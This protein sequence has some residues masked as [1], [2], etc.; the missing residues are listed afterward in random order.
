MVKRLATTLSAAACGI[1]FAQSAC[2][3]SV[4]FM[5]AVI[6]QHGTQQLDYLTTFVEAKPTTTT[7]P[8][9]SLA[10]SFLAGQA[11]DRPPMDMA[12]LSSNPR[13]SG[14]IWFHYAQALYD[15]GEHDRAQQALKQV[16]SEARAAFEPAW[17]D[18]TLRLALRSE[19]VKGPSPDN[20]QIEGIAALNAVLKRLSVSQRQQSIERLRRLA[21]AP[22]TPVALRHRATIWATLLLAEQGETRDGFRLFNEI[23]GAS[24]LAPETLLAYT[25][26]K[27]NL[28]PQ[29]IGAIAEHIKQAAPES[30]AYRELQQLLI[31]RLYAQGAVNQAAKIALVNI[32]ELQQI[33]AR[34]RSHRQRVASLPIEELSPYIAIIPTTSQARVQRLVEARDR[35]QRS[36]HLLQE[37]Q[38]HVRSYQQI[39]QRNPTGFARQIDNA[40]SELNIKIRNSNKDT[41]TLEDLFDFELNKLLGKPPSQYAGY[42]IFTGLAQWEFGATYPRGWQPQK[43]SSAEIRRALEH[44]SQL[45]DRINNRI[46]E[47]PSFPY[48]GMSQWAKTIVTRNQSHATVIQRAM[49][50]VEQAIRDEVIASLA[51]RQQREENWLVQFSRHA[52]QLHQHYQ[53]GSSSPV[54]PLDKTLSLAAGKPILESLLQFRNERTDS[55]VVNVDFAPAMAGLAMIIEHSRSRLHLANALLLRAHLNVSLYETGALTDTRAATSHY[56]ELLSEY[57]DL[58]DTAEIT[59]HLAKAEA[60]NQEMEASLNTLMRFTQR[61]PNDSRYHEA[62]FRIGEL[63]F[64][65]SDYQF[66]RNAY[67]T[68]V[69]AGENRFSE[70]ARYKLAWTLFK[71]G[72][73]QEALPRFVAV[74]DS[75]EQQGSDNKQLANRAQDAFRA[76]SLTFS[77]LKGPISIENYFAK[78][79]TR[80]YLADVYHNLA[81]FYLDHSR[82]SDAAKTYDYLIIHFPTDH[83]A[84]TLLAGV[85]DAARQERLSKLALTL[86]EQFVD[87]Y[88]IDGTYWQTAATQTK[89]AIRDQLK[90]YLAQLAQMYH[91]DAQQQ[92]KRDS[93]S[94]AIDYYERYVAAFPHDTETPHLHFLMAEARFEKGAYFDAMVDYEKVAY[95]YGA[96][97]DAA[98]AGYAALLANQKLVV[99]SVFEDDKKTRL[100]S[101]VAR[102]RRFA[103]SF[104][105]DTRVNDVMVK[106]SED[107][108]ML[109][110]PGEAVDLGELL[111]K[112][113]PEASIQRR[114]RVVI[115]HGYFESDRFERA[116]SA[117]ETA[118]K[119]KGHSPTQQD[120][121]YQRLALSVYR[122]AEQYQQRD[123]TEKAIATFLRVAREAPQ[124]EIVPNAEIDAAALLLANS[125]WDDAI[126]VFERFLKQFPK[127]KL[128][129]DVPTKLA[130]AYEK[131][132]RLLLAA[133]MQERLSKTESDDALARQMLWRAAELRDNGGR[134]D[135]AVATF[136]RYLQR[137]PD[138]LEKATEVRQMLAD[139]ATR[140]GD[141]K[142]RD[143]WLNAIISSHRSAGDQ[144]P[145][146]VRFLAAQANVTLGDSQAEAFNAIKLTL[147]L[148]RSLT[149]KRRSLEHA[150][151]WYERAGRYGVAE[152]T[153]AATYKTASL[154]RQLARDL[155][156]SE[157]PRGLNDLEIQQYNIL[158]EEEAFPFEDK[159]TELHE[160]NYQRIAEGVYDQWIKRTMVDLRKLLPG[161]YDKVEQTEGVFEYIPPQ[162]T[163]E[164]T[165]QK[166]G[167]RDASSPR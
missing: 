76:L 142:T 23:D 71:L 8:A 65:L 4:N 38:P 102:S 53:A 131:D 103:D 107:I 161:R 123:E 40:F 62:M 48:D 21:L 41:K 69:N 118:L 117:Y 115:A 106:A 5:D 32:Q 98:E 138:P 151:K 78:A 25:R 157:R 37:W 111:L 52:L 19:N 59:Y 165:E 153:T 16:S 127:H 120:E 124:A 91:A 18:L 70:Q 141:I 55:A 24:P 87:R 135:L 132:G 134:K 80:P 130:Y 58:V 66:A 73:Y 2:A 167:G 114:A 129:A 92:E 146:R 50:S 51:S 27:P 35:L 122:Q 113:N 164:N 26:L 100:R 15:R 30:I 108:L 133:D 156:A 31:E 1:L 144:A 97:K 158:L 94:Q 140:S 75:A 33:V 67:R 60:L 145:V 34:L 7:T 110:E 36:I 56:R 137:Y 12:A 10:E 89:S 112:R 160:V 126:D 79:G 13:L 143:R 11:I 17:Q 119:D 43:R 22:S 101:L 95:Q 148:D 54:Y 9:H 57:P 139:I 74:I 163:P 49:P 154:Y 68:V 61:F 121:L 147:P 20:I 96:H 99:E 155:M 44:S 29:L 39:L 152:I 162:P 125:Q 93:L 63:Q 109:N 64:S 105:D 136:E 85:V 81:T 116:E 3:A 84:P 88:R 150:L 90:P 45:L 83:R 128:A 104:T 42:Q 47:L 166:E 159:A 86:Q 46:R 6:S 77:Y 14:E 149:R 82:V 28:D 72:R